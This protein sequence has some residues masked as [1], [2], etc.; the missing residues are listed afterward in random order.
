MLDI[1]AQV[2]VELIDT[3]AAYGESES[4]LGRSLPA[5]HSFRIVTKTIPLR[6]RKNGAKDAERIEQG[7]RAS[8]G[9]LGQRRVYALLVHHA[10]DLLAPDGAR[11]VE[12]LRKLKAEG[13]TEKIG[14]SV[15]DQRQIEA[16]QSRHSVDVVQ[17]P[18]NVLD[19]RLLASG[20]L[21]RLREQGVEVHARSVFLQGLL[22]MDPDRLG[23]HFQPAVP[24]LRRFHEFARE[25]G[26]TPLQAALAFVADLKDIDYAVIGVTRHEELQEIAAAFRPQPDLRDSLASFALQDESV[27]NPARWPH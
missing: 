7:F 21:T 6:P 2:G 12:V 24:T 26:M 15:Y 22:L 25:K 13:L 3:A 20:T 16:I 8:L 14:V 23:A 10:E 18:V 5:G 17:A 19:Q 4:V 1:A 9:N 27:L 11:L